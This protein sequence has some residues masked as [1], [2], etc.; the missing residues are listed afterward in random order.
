MVSK[1]FTTSFL[2]I[3]ALVLLSD[4]CSGRKSIDILWSWNSLIL[5]PIGFRSSGRDVSIQRE[6]I[7]VRDRD[8]RSR[9]DG[10]GRGFGGFRGNDFGGGFGGFR[11]NSFGGGFGFNRGFSGFDGFGPSRFSTGFALGAIAASNT[12]GGLGSLGGLGGVGPLGGLGGV[13][14]VPGVPVVVASAG[15]FVI[16]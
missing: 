9:D 14:V 16:G 6:T 8:F 4:V 13:A 10:Y 3:L 1:I 2:A 15:S 11:G 12:L 5:F 7:R